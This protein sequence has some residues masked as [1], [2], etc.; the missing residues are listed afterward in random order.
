MIDVPFNDKESK[1]GHPT[2]EF[3]TYAHDFET[4]LYPY[5]NRHKLLGVL[6]FSALLHENIYL[7]DT[8]LGDN[9]YILGDFRYR[10]GQGLDL[11][12]DEFTKAGILR[13]LIRNEVAIPDRDKVLVAKDPTLWDTYRGWLERDPDSTEK[14]MTRWHGKVRERYYRIKD[15]L[16]F[17]RF[18]ASIIRYDPDEHKP[19]YRETILDLVDGRSSLHDL[20]AQLPEQKRTTYIQVLRNPFFTNVDLWKVVKDMCNAPETSIRNLAN[21]LIIAQCHINQLCYAD[22]VRSGMTGTDLTTLS[23]VRFNLEATSCIQQEESMQVSSEFAFDDLFEQADWKMSFPPIELL[24]VLSPKDIFEMRAV[25]N[26]T[27][28]KV[29]KQEFGEKTLEQ[30]RDDYVRALKEYLH[31]IHEYLYRHYPTARETQESSLGLFIPGKLRLYGRH[32]DVTRVTGT[33][34]FWLGV[35]IDLALQV[36]IPIVGSFINDKVKE[37]IRKR[38]DKLGLVLLYSKAPGKLILPYVPSGGVFSTHGNWSTS[39]SPR[40]LKQE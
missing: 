27:I 17:H 29:I 22:I 26:M 40:S 3:S 36:P 28:F 7:H 35:L 34:A 33:I 30:I 16:L 18:P 6:N 12:I 8:A 32:V 2:R 10:R 20:V 21:K 25:A 4:I 31:Y 1:V 9:P 39:R 24:G 14:F 5:T 38:L 13:F 23:L 19:A 15:D 11:A 37:W